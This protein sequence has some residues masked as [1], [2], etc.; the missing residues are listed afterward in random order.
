MR[1]PRLIVAKVCRILGMQFTT[2]DGRGSCVSKA[3]RHMH[4]LIAAIVVFSSGEILSYYK[5]T[6]VFT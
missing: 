3:T 1:G 6:I 4:Q 2:R 5:K